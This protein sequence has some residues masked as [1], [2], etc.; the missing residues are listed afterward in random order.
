MQHRGRFLLAVNVNIKL[1]VNVTHM[2]A[3]ILNTTV[4]VDDETRRRLKQLAAVLDETQGSI[5]RKALAMYESWV[6][7]Q[8]VEK[9]VPRR[10]ARELEKASAAIR[11]KD[12][13]WA[14]VSDTL[15]IDTTSLEEFS[16][17][18]WG[19]EE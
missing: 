10:V 18:L 14:M 4:T 19:K 3:D 1:L 5:V 8:G 15:E 16:P 17:A 9:K 7:K 6:K 2:W 12:P 11:S 13:K